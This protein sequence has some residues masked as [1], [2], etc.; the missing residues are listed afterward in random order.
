MS[1]SLPCLPNPCQ[2]IDDCWMGN[3]APAVERV[4]DLNT[5]VVVAGT[6]QEVSLIEVTGHPL[7]V[8]ALPLLCPFEWIGDREDLLG[9]RTPASLQ[10]LGRRN[11]CTNADTSAIGHVRGCSCRR[12]VEG[13]D[14]YTV[15]Q[16]LVELRWSCRFRRREA[17]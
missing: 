9:F 13:T 3:E 1:E 6:D 15:P 11:A 7:A 14:V 17:D 8:L 2:Q 12:T 10:E 16:E 4:T 5:A